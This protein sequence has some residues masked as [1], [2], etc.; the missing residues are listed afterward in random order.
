MTAHFPS[1]ADHAVAAEID[2][3]IGLLMEAQSRKRIMDAWALG[4]ITAEIAME[5]F[6]ALGLIESSDGVGA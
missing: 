4:W 2:A 3:L 5:A 1:L 6:L